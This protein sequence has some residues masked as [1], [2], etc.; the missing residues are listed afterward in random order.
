MKFFALLLL[1]GTICTAADKSP[2]IADGAELK[3]LS[4]E[5]S[6]TEGPTP[7]K[8]GNV[9]FTDQPN[10]RIMKYTIDG[11]METFMQPAGRSNGLY[12]NPDGKLIACADEN[13]EMWAINVN[14]KSKEVIINNYQGMRLNAPNDVWV[15][16]KGGIYFSDP[17]Y[18]RNW[19]K[20]TKSEQDAEAVYYLAP[21]A[22]EIIRVAENFKKPNGLIGTPDGKLLYISDIG[23]KKTYVYAIQED[24]TLGERTLFCSQG[25]DGMTIDSDGNIYLT[26]KGVSV[27]DKTGKQI[28][29]IDIKG[30]TANVC[31]GGKDMKTLFITSTKTFYAIDM[32]VNGF[33]R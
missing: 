30:W 14:D 12:F 15:D 32:K 19:W 10:D 11:K 33:G 25:S 26:G 24:G 2:V 27:F 31:F 18:K 3:A 20:H 16:A 6:F 21:G 28:E 13:N 4:Q 7:D 5:F 1:L 17:F 23:D 9:Y 29:Q 22:K 8:Q